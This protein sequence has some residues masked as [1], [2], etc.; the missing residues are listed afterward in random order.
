MDK[1]VIILV[2][3]EANKLALSETGVLPE[4][5]HVLLVTSDLNTAE[6]CRRWAQ[7][8]QV[9]HH[10]VALQKP[11]AASEAGWDDSYYLTSAEAAF[12]HNNRTLYSQGDR[13]G[14][15]SLADARFRS[16]MSTDLP[17]QLETLYEGL[18]GAGKDGEQV[19]VTT[20]VI[21]TVLRHTGTAASPHLLALAQR[22]AAKFANHGDFNFIVLA[23]SRSAGS[24]ERA[25]VSR[26]VFLTE[27]SFGL[28]HDMELGPGARISPQ[29]TSHVFEIGPE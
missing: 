6:Q 9:K 27:V 13:N 2:G 18:V 15:S 1:K 29:L 17:E 8:D 16:V 24:E 5:C 22:S 25:I 14:A 3:D 28:E 23:A 20:F 7:E 12:R 21:P 19:R 4:D 10:W 11:H 26:L